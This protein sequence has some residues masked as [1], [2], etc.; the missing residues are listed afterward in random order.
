MYDV[1]YDQSRFRL[2]IFFQIYFVRW[3]YA[4]LLSCYHKKPMQVLGN[5]A[6]G[7]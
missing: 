6:E 3:P 2:V 5:Y 7:K 4:I 1:D